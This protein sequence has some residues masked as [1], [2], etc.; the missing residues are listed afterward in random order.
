M[1]LLRQTGADR[2]ILDRCGYVRVCH[3]DRCPLETL[4]KTANAWTVEPLHDDRE[5]VVECCIQDHDPSHRYAVPQEE[6]TARKD[7]QPMAK[8]SPDTFL[9]PAFQIGRV[10]RPQSLQRKGAP[11][12]PGAIGDET[13]PEPNTKEALVDPATLF[14]AKRPVKTLIGI[15]PFHRHSRAAESDAHV[16]HHPRSDIE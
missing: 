9:Q 7:H 8:F 3:R 2:L 12:Q 6:E 15:E 16:Q 5:E 1:F 11:I 10:Q 14:P 4:K 13:L